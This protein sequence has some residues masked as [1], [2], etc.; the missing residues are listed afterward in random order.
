MIKYLSHNSYDTFAVS[1]A[2]AVAGMP[3]G[4]GES[5][6]VQSQAED[7]DINVLM[8]RFGLT[9]KM[10]EDVRV[11]QYG[12]FTQVMDYRSAL[13][14]LRSAD[15]SFAEL[16][17]DVRGRFRNDPQL[18]LEFCSD[19]NNRAEAQRLG[20]LK[21]QPVAPPGAPGGPG[22]TPPGGGGANPPA[23]SPGG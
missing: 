8:R 23:S 2:S 19:A 5:L 14:A 4:P 18:L 9:G 21:A 11:P 17:A 22:A 12:D 15:E 20:L 13:D 1:H 7:A 10:P 16:P 6:T 3:D